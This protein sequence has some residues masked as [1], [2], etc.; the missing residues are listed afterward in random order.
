MTSLLT[1]PVFLFLSYSEFVVVK[2]ATLSSFRRSSRYAVTISSMVRS[3]SFD[4]QWSWNAFSPEWIDRSITRIW[5]DRENDDDF[6]GVGGEW[7]DPSEF[8]VWRKRNK[9]ERKVIWKLRLH[10]LESCQVPQSPCVSPFFLCDTK[11]ETDRVS[12]S[13]V[14]VVS[15]LITSLQGSSVRGNEGIVNSLPET[16]A[17]RLRRN[18]LF[19]LLRVSSLAQ[20]NSFLIWSP[21]SFS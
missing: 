21:F 16:K 7:W 1:H 10:S 6:V 17:V 20:L 18:K 19:T 12:H 14:L 8:L 15:F 5:L 2:Y 4:H 13:F 11:T 3:S 9:G